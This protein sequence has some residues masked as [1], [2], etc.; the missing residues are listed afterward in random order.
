MNPNKEKQSHEKVK[1]QNKDKGKQINEMCLIIQGLYQ[2]VQMLIA[3]VINTC[4]D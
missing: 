4:S 3:I 1:S 2:Q